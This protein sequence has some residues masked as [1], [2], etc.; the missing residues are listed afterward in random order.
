MI[1]LNAPHDGED[2][3]ESL[4]D[5]GSGDEAD[6]SATV[7]ISIEER[8]T[9]VGRMTRKLVECRQIVLNRT[10][11][12]ELDF[13]VG[14]GERGATIASIHATDEDSGLVS[15]HFLRRFAMLDELLTISES[16]LRTGELRR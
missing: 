16:C 14:P 12:S 3:R 15:H 6:A 7:D 5:G 2:G 4:G 11:E 10:A 13:V 1:S 8:T 9:L